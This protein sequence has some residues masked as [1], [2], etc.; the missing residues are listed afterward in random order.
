M[1]TTETISIILVEP[2][3]TE[4]E[5]RAAQEALQMLEGARPGSEEDSKRTRIARMVRDYEQRGRQA[6]RNAGEASAEWT[7]EHRSGIGWIAAGAASV[8]AAGLGL[9]RW[10]KA[11]Q[12]A[13][14]RGR[15]RS[16]ADRSTKRAE[17][18]G[19]A[20]K[21]AG[22]AGWKGAKNRIKNLT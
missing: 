11:K 21:N 18:V 10:R 20:S 8:V 16:L 2:I 4:A 15:L 12:E 22:K 17:K 3:A 1:Q 14:V 13:T 5:L 9:V 6:V 19:K 7:S